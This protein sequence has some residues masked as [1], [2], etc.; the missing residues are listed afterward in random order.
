MDFTRKGG[1]LISFTDHREIG[2]KKVNMDQAM[3]QADQFLKNK[4]YPDM[5][6]VTADQYENMGNFT[7][8]RK[9]D[10]VYIYPD[11]MTVRVGLDDGNVTGFQASDFIYEESKKHTITKPKLTLS[12]VRRKLNP[13]FKETY[14][15]LALIEDDL[16]QESLCYEF[17]GN[18]NGSKYRIYLS[19]EDGTEK[20]VEEIRTSGK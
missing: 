12:E 3:I 18:I 20:A 10:G 15:R 17:G 7:Y 2:Q 13:E 5:T 8:V 14:N 6:A 11:K 4:G 16:S 9:Q 1:R 19:T